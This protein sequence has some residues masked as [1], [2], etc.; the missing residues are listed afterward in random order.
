MRRAKRVN[1]GAKSWILLDDR[2]SVTLAAQ[3]FSESPAE[4]VTIPR[5]IFNQLIEFYQK[6]QTKKG[7]VKNGP[8]Y[9]NN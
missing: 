6:D 3:R 1:D 2:Y 8:A 4:S 7:E 5:R 9:D